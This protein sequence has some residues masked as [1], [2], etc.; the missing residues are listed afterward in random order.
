MNEVVR[1]PLKINARQ[2]EDMARKGAFATVGRVELRRGM[3]TLMSPVYRPHARLLRQL[4]LA[5]IEALRG[6]EDGLT[7]DPEVSVRLGEDFQPTADLVVWDQKEVQDHAEGPVPSDLVRA[8]IEVADTSVDDDLGDKLAEYALAGVV[9]YWVADVK[10][11]VLFIHTLPG[12][13]GYGTRVEVPF[14]QAVTSPTL[15][16]TVETSGL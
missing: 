8:V 14:G 1:N 13:E 6:R 7:V 9:E 2:F 11:R 10:R 4:L 3:M 16:L 15:G 12:L 5:W